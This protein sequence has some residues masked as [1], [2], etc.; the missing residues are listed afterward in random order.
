M[1]SFLSDIG[2]NRTLNEDYVTFYEDENLKICIIADGMGGYN[3][4]EVASKVSAETVIS[5]FKDNYNEIKLPKTL[6]ESISIAN[7][8]V[9][10]LSKSNDSLNGMGTTIT[11]AVI[12][13]NELYVAN[14]GD[15]SC[16]I[17]KDN[18]ILKIT[19]DHSFVQELIDIGTLKEEDAKNH[20]Q[21]NVLT[22]ALGIS[23]EV[24]I[25]IFKL[26]FC[27]LDK[28][29]LCTDG[30]TNYVDKV[31]ILNAVNLN[32][33]S[34]VCEELINLSKTRGGRDNISI[35]VCG[36]EK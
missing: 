27:V 12:K 18:E 19:K 33:N 28:V 10:K 16:F 5:Y 25:D 17:I 1:V 14:I 2:N 21:K 8:K 26:D 20:P 36:G 4:G 3:A 15:S 29:I 30:L 23:L 35:I 31:E 34:E 6:E 13:N 24:K 7:E 11:V 9:Y 22:R 32:N